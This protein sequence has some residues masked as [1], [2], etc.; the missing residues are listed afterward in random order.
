[1][2]KKKVYVLDS[3]SIIA[4]LNDEEGA[5]IVGEL[6]K[7]AD[8]GTVKLFMHVINLGEIFYIVFREKGEV[9][10]INVYSKIRQYP[11]EFVED[12]SEPFLL[13]AASIK[14]TYPVSYADA[15]VAATAIE[16]NGTLVTGDPEFKCV[17]IKIEIFWIQKH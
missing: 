16:K 10:A 17:E 5:D 15:F 12:L 9:E 6:L 8:K 11:V 14:G 7:E 13:T 4:Y 1:M 3:F 2:S